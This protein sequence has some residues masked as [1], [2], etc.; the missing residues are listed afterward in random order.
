LLASVSA[1]ARTDK[2]IANSSVTAS[3]ISADELKSVFLQEKNSLADRSHGQLVL[4]RLMLS[5]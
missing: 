4:P 2:I 1:Q 3:S 5:F